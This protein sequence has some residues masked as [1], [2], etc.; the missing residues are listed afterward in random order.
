MLPPH[1]SY[2]HKIRIEGPEG[3]ESLGYSPLQH[4]S[5]LELQETKQ[6]LEENLQRG[7]IEPSQSPFASPILFVKKPSGALRFCVDYRKLNNLTQK[8]RL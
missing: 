3:P 1:R 4:Q 7:F 5:T 2:D 6:F 8:D